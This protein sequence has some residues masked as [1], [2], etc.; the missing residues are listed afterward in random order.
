MTDQVRQTDPA[1]FYEALGRTMTALRESQALDGAERLDWWPGLGG[2]TWEIEWQAGPFAHEAADV[3]LRAAH[4]EDLAAHALHGRVQ[5]GRHP[6]E[7]YAHL[8]VL[9]VPVTLRA[10]TPVGVREVLHRMAARAARCTP[11]R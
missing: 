9:D 11:R 8:V 1:R 7:H 10:L 2:V 3:V 6:N 4:G 5:E